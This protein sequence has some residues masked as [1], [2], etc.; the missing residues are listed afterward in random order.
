MSYGKIWTEDEMINLSFGTG[1]S[2]TKISKERT[3]RHKERK[4]RC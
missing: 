2:V 3:E 4:E 1:M